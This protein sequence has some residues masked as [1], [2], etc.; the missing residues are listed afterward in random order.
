MRLKQLLLAAA[1]AYALAALARY[2]RREEEEEPEEEPED[3]ETTTVHGVQVCDPGAWPPEGI[4]GRPD[5]PLVAVASYNTLRR[6]YRFRGHDWVPGRHRDFGHRRSLLL[7]QLESFKA[8]LLCLQECELR[9]LEEDFAEPL[10]KLGYDFVTAD[11][12]GGHDHT[13]PV[14]FYDKSRFA[15]TWSKPKSRVVLAEFREKSSGDR[16][17]VAACHL[18]GGNH[19]PTRYNQARSLMKAMDSRMREYAKTPETPTP[20]SSSGSRSPR[21]SRSPKDTKKPGG[22]TEDLSNEKAPACIVC[23][24]MNAFYDD[25]SV[26]LFKTGHMRRNMW[27]PMDG[28]PPRRLDFRAGHVGG[29]RDAYCILDEESRPF[30]YQYGSEDCKNKVVRMVV[31]YIFYAERKENVREEDGTRLTLRALRRPFGKSRRKPLASVGIP[32]GWHPSDHLPLAALFEMS[33][34]PGSSIASSKV[35]QLPRSQAGGGGKH[36]RRTMAG[37]RGELNKAG[38]IKS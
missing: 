13:K 32:N 12:K 15:M 17:L 20:R 22:P 14:I 27:N 21:R 18:Q 8:D 29:L 16:I 37:G 25:P 1:A 4:A 38:K 19:A 31:D 28:E 26:R 24:D 30:T 10:R 11:P 3:R 36:N 6:N 33:S 7:R 2:L 34:S 35:S 23:G 5:C 9:S